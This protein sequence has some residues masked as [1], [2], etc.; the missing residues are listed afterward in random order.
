MEP[1]DTK[2]TLDLLR[3]L[4]DDCKEQQLG[5][6]CAM[7]T[8]M[9]SAVRFADA[10]D[11]GPRRKWAG[12]FGTLRADLRNLQHALKHEFMLDEKKRSEQERLIDAALE[13]LARTTDEELLQKAKEDGVNVESLAAELRARIEAGIRSLSADPEHKP[14]LEGGKG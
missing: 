12:H 3:R 4:R 5:V 11:N 2:E 6:E 7:V 13:D 10:F 14:Q 8:A 1:V 9:M